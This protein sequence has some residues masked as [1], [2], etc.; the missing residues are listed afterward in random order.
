MPP[1]EK[2]IDYPGF[3]L[4][5]KLATSPEQQQNDVEANNVE[6]Y[7]KLY[8]ER[9]R[10]RSPN[11][12]SSFGLCGA[13][14][15]ANGALGPGETRKRPKKHRD[16]PGLTPRIFGF[17]LVEKIDTRRVECEEVLVLGLLWV[18]RA[19]VGLFWLGQCG[20]L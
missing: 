15:V 6:E 19:N 2:I 8:L 7:T 10:L 16:P 3:G 4:P 11:A 17:H 14:R 20:G 5:S 1:G 12:V 18:I 13:I 9:D